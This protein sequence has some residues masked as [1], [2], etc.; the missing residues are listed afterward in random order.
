[1]TARE[2]LKYIVDFVP[3]NKLDTAII[4]IEDLLEFSEEE[5]KALRDAMEGKNLIGPF[6]TP[7]EMMEAL[8]SDKTDEELMQECAIREQEREKQ[9]I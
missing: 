8:L 1:M 4:A 6:N 7:E 9:R 5:Q 3:E 2:E